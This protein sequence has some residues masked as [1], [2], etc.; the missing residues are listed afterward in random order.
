MKFPRIENA[1]LNSKRA[2]LRIEGTGILDQ[3][4]VIYN[5]I[6]LL[7]VIPTIKFLLQ[8]GASVLILTNTS[9]K[10][11]PQADELHALIEYF[12]KELNQTVD[13]I[14]DPFAE[15]ALGGGS[16]KLS[17]VAVL[18]NL[19][20][21]PEERSNKHSFAKKL[22]KLGD[23]Y[24]NDARSANGYEYASVVELTKLLP[25]FIGLG[26]HQ[27]LLLLKSLMDT[28]RDKFCLIVGGVNLDK[29]LSFLSKCVTRVNTI[30]IGGGIA[31]GFLYS[32]A[33]P[34]GRSLREADLD[35]PAFQFLEKANFE[36][37]KV[38]L[39]TDHLLSKSIDAD[40]SCK[41][42]SSIPQ[43]WLG[44]EIGNKTLKYFESLVKKEPLIVWYGPLGVT[45][46][47]K[48][49]RGSFRLAKTLAKSKG[50]VFA[51]GDETC[52]LIYST[53]K[54]QNYDCLESNS[55]FVL[56]VLLDVPLPG[57]IAI[58]ENESI[59]ES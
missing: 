25:S 16:N 43:D 36:K 2:L 31:Y 48:Y 42:S 59:N 3:N 38:A 52:R 24:V 40:A 22:A 27:R 18:E 41:N 26:L 37:V 46:L 19:D 10:I 29:K 35:V 51:I 9:D 14:R 47:D 21:Y 57:I 11:K 45:E 33:I 17:Q 58:Q 12:S 30:L 8:R 5:P 34:I 6:P 54:H 1:Q 50:Q 7:A 44:V 15:Q 28:Q 4:S 53:A 23:V 39:P 13:Y 55:E 49:S 20:F 32:R 56:K